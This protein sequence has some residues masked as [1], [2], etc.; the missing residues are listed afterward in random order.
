MRVVSGV[1]FICHEDIPWPTAF[2]QVSEDSDALVAKFEPGKDMA[3]NVT[4]TLK[5]AASNSS[6]SAAGDAPVIDVVAQD[7]PSTS[8]A[9][10]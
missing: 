1:I 4:L 3:F 6:S 10:A 9:A 8:A 7:L 5:G 2:L